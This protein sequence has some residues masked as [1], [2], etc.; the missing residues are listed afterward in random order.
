MVNF[1]LKAKIHFVY[2]CG[3]GIEIQTFCLNY[4]TKDKL[5]TPNTKIIIDQ[6]KIFVLIKIFM[7]NF[8][9]KAAV[10]VIY[11]IF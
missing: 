8:V 1:T 7:L 3:F 2:V 4:F 9:I 10:I 5:Y 6:I 11:V